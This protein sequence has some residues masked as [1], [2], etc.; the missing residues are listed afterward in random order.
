VSRVHLCGAAVAPFGKHHDRSATDLGA[1]A[2]ADLLHS[3]GIDPDDVQAGFVGS[4][5]GGS[6][7]A[8]RVL[9]RVGISGPPVFTIENACASGGSAVHLG[10]QA[11]ASGTYDCVLAVGV[12]NL[13]AFGG[14]TLP[15]TTAD[16]ETDQGVVMP[17]TYA[18]RA[19]RYLY[20]TGATATDLARVS[21]KNRANGALNPRA[22]FQKPVT[23]DEVAASRPIA[24]P[25][26]LLHCCPNSDGAAAVLLCSEGFAAELGTPQTTIQASVVRSGRFHTSYRDMTWPDITARAATAAYAMA[27]LGPADLDIV[28]LHDAFAIA[29]FL[30]AEALG[31]TERGSAYKAVANGEFDRDGRVAVS[32][33]GGLLSRGHPV[34]ATG[35][36]QLAEAHYQLTSTAGALQVAGAQVALTHTTGGGIFGVD[37]GACSVHILTARD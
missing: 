24:D 21:V 13:S 19:Q 8:Q 26:R 12:D 2:A 14:G 6:L 18:M 7:I 20:E 36:S 10:W 32:P 37:N 17:A 16:V 15:L 28:E 35:V 22:H 25:L 23:A 4:V 30:H 27:G 34:G 9:Q 29:E 5:Y 33:S 31:L 11:I 3:S 1:A